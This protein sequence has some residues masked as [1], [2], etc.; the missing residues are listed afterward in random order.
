M[1]HQ[2]PLITESVATIV[3]MPSDIAARDYQR[4]LRIQ[5]KRREHVHRAARNLERWL[6]SILLQEPKRALE[7][8]RAHQNGH[9]LSDDFHRPLNRAIFEACVIAIQEQGAVTIAYIK[10]HLAKEGLPLLNTHYLEACAAIFIP[11]G[12][13]LM[14]CVVAL[15]E[16][17]KIGVDR[18]SLEVVPHN[19][20][21]ILI[22]AD[23]IGKI[24]EER[25]AASN[26]PPLLRFAA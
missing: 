21:P 4:A 11:P 3:S 10:K 24:E 6:I 12:L 18:E 17:R 15:H 13:T 2:L 19:P 22:A 8:A 1:S 14:H 23:D 20:Q 26:L 5:R 16:R 9:L 25:L 7:I